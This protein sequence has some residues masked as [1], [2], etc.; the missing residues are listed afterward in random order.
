[1]EN[2]QDRDIIRIAECVEWKVVRKV[3]LRNVRTQTRR[4]VGILVMVAL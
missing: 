1:M 4:Q 2:L 3:G